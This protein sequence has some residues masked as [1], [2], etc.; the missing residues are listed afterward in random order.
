MRKCIRIALTLTG[1]VLAI[2]CGFA[3]SAPPVADTFSEA[4][5]HGHN[6]GTFPLLAFAAD[7]NSYLQ[8]D[9]SAVPPG[10]AVSK[11][12]LR[13]FVSA[14][15]SKGRFDVYELGNTWGESTLSFNNAPGLRA[16]A[17]GGHSIAVTS[18]NPGET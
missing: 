15:E 4:S 5:A 17:T 7:A 10:A 14:V 13:L 1:N 8:F 18:A 9:L 11:A 2:S 12:T 3:H 6:F 16:S